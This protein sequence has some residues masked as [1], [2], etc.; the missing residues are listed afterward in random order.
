[1]HEVM[2]YRNYRFEVMAMDVR[3]ILKVKVTVEAAE[4][5]PDKNPG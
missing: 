3:R 4:V 5:E 1:M 2:L